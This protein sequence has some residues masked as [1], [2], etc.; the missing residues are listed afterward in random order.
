MFG[1]GYENSPE[2]ANQKII[3]TESKLIA[4]IHVFMATHTP[5]T[6]IH[7]HSLSWFSETFRLLSVPDEGYSRNPS[8]ALNLIST[9]LFFY[10]FL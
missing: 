3:E 6:R 4:L 9:F 8:C 2:F 10:I 5:D 7:D 1:S